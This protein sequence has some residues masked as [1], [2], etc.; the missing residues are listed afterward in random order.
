MTHT[1]A[2]SFYSK[3]KREYS[4]QLKNFEFHKTK[5]ERAYIHKITSEYKENDIEIYLAQ[6]VNHV[7]YDQINLKHSIQPIK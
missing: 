1:S 7:I 2:Y 4:F 6:T 3:K 5:L